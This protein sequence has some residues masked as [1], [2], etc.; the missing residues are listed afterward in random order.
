MRGQ[1]V[2]ETNLVGDSTTSGGNNANKRDY[3]LEAAIDL[4]Y[5]GTEEYT[6]SFWVPTVSFDL[7][8]CA[9]C[10][11]VPALAKYFFIQRNSWQVYHH[12]TRILCVY[13]EQWEDPASL[14][15]VLLWTDYSTL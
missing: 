10:L 13:V 14:T 7:H 2:D 8:S 11:A 9:L 6:H 4:A 15:L 12:P 3:Q 5:E 1:Q